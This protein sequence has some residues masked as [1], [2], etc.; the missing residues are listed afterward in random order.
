[1]VIWWFSYFFAMNEQCYEC[2]TQKSFSFSAMCY[3]SAQILKN[4]VA[5]LGGISILDF[6][7]YFGGCYCSGFG[8]GN[9]TYCCAQGL[10]LPFCSRII[11]SDALEIIWSARNWTRFIYMPGKCSTHC[12]ISPTLFWEFVFLKESPYYFLKNMHQ[13][14]FLRTVWE[15][16]FLPPIPTHIVS[17]PYDISHSH[18]H[19]NV[20]LWFLFAIPWY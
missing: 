1:M 15:F 2:R 12:T 19:E 9:H 6:F 7:F 18:I 14:I 17:I 11:F 13:F 10:L 16:L 8:L 5:G 20:S 3:I 4:S